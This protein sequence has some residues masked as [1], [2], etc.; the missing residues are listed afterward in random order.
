MLIKK[1]SSISF[2]ELQ[3]VVARFHHL[4]SVKRCDKPNEEIMVKALNKLPYHL[5]A[6][7]GVNLGG[8]GSS[9]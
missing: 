5:K 8:G 6:R 2:L 9:Y 4:T 3:E 1:I 7:K